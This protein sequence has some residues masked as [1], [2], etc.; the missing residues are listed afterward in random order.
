MK[1][2]ITLLL[3]VT[4]IAESSAFAAM[5]NTNSQTMNQAGQRNIQT[6]T[7]N[8]QPNMNIPQNSG[9]LNTNYTYNQ[10]NYG[11]NQYP[12]Y[13]VNQN[14]SINTSA[15]SNNYQNS[16]DSSNLQQYQLSPIEELFNGKELDVT[17]KP[18]LQAGYDLFSSTTSSVNGT[19]GKF[20]NNYR[21]NIGEKVNVYLYGDS[22]DVMAISG[23][24][25][26]NPS[27]KTEID[28]KGNLFVQGI[29]IVPAEN[30]TISEVENAI[31]RLAAQKY[32]SLKVRLTVAAGQ[33]FSVFVYGQ[34][35]RPGKVLVGNN[36]SVFDALNA[37][38]G[39]K[40]TGTLRNISYTSNGK[41]RQVDLYKTLFT[42]SDDNIILRPNDKIF[43]D[44]I[45]NVVAI[46]NGVTVPGIYEI[47]EGEN[48]QKAIN[49]A[50]G[51]LPATQVTEV[52]LTSFD[53][54][55]R[56]KSADNISWTEAKNTKL[57]SGD[58][59][60]FRE[61]YNNAENIVTIQGNVKHPTTYA[62]KE[63]MRLSDIL[64]SEDEL[65]EETF[66][67]Q[68]VIRRV[69]GKDNSI[70]TIP[71]F[72]KE[73]F[74]GMNDPI[75]QPKDI[76]NVYKNTNSTFVDVYGC[77]N[78]PKHLTYT[79]KMTLNDVMTDIQFLESDIKDTDEKEAE[80]SF[81]GS[82]E[83]NG[84]QL[85]AGTTNSNKLIPAENVAVEI[86][87]ADGTTQLYYLYDIMINSDR[88]KSIS[89]LPEDK[90]FFRTLRGN[91]VM[92]TVKVSGFV[93]HPGV[94]TFVEGK[95]LVDMINMAGGLTKEADLRGIVFKRTNLQ[96]KQAELARKNNERDIKLLEGRM[97]SAYKP[98]EGDQQNKLDL[99]NMLKTDEQS[100]NKQYNGQIALNI[101]S[102]DLDK[103]RDLDNIEV[104]D[105]DDIYIPR[106][107]NHVSVIGEVYNEQ[108]FVFKKGANAKYYIKEVGG[109][110]P[111]ANK[112]RLYKVSVNGRAE[113]I[114]NGS[115][116]EPGDTIVVPRR[117][118]GNDWITPVCDTLK[119]I[120]SIIVMAFAINKW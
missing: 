22:V 51:L 43:V 107:S 113:K 13:G 24:N 49:Y 4:F 67:N 105:G 56:Q 21:L 11:M 41:T 94:Y 104:Q 37:A 97:A 10:Q 118:A 42:A 96:G 17:G 50:G 63:G 117:V 8:Q 70:E 116:I 86:T 5:V 47:K 30:K 31:N 68:A 53:T 54:K 44:K 69:S 60:E 109:Y 76:I 9:M 48:L 103:I 25:L 87:G 88:I 101:K 77:V 58:A 28:S 45:G 80:V 35:N 1:K 82:V 29:G 20:D 119:G 26:L 112:F 108:S 7:I 81:K 2:F 34:V 16:V 65:L 32:K 90:I 27:T 115:S 46:K 64:K 61:L 75:L 106:T 52:T 18:L 33:D 100:I 12:S 79:E 114:S 89:I 71:V 95:N 85:E 84:V 57:H 39:V 15:F 66:I 6:Q 74:A 93:K 98:T 91:E 102:N 59:V 111:N 14:E 19:T 38:G 99:I 110:T 120:A 3:L 40:K 92:K 23:A 72:L 36:S 62:Y 55:T 73:F 78:I 83:E